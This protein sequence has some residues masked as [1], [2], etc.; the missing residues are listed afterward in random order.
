MSAQ[1][2]N[3]AFIHHDH[4]RCIDGTLS[5]ARNLCASKGLKLTPIRERVLTFICQSHKPLGAYAILDLLAEEEKKRTDGKGRRPA[6]PTVYRALEFL[7]EYGLVHR[8][9]TLNAYVG[10]CLPA[11]AHQSHFLICRQ[12]D[13][14][15]E[16]ASTTISQ[17]IDN[18]ARQTN[19]H[20][21]YECVEVIGLCPA[22]Y[23]AKA[24][25]HD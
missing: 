11:K 10:C 2:D 15:V 14:T 24:D 1:T 23:S 13:N 17:A 19:F 18:A 6:P 9:A 16:F 12:C 25:S 21:D 22:C 4:N 7:Q 20:V 8:I 5:A 3:R